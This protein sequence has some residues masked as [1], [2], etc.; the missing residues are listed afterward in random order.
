MQN[1]CESST[2]TTTF[3]TPTLQIDSKHDEST[4]AVEIDDSLLSEIEKLISLLKKYD[5][6]HN[7]QS[8]TLEALREKMILEKKSKDFKISKEK[9]LRIIISEKLR[10]H[11]ENRVLEI[12]KVRRSYS[13][14]K[15]IL[16][17]IYEKILKDQSQIEVLINEIYSQQNNI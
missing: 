16:D 3:L 13:K 8:W 17:A 5:I 15:W 6:R 2:G 7:V 12:K 14:K 9:F 4:Y 11:I 1:D 10:Q